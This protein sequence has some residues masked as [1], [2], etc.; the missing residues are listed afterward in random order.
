[1]DFSKCPWDDKVTISG[2]SAI[3]GNLDGQTTTLDEMRNSGID[4][5]KAF[6]NDDDLIEMQ[7]VSTCIGFVRKYTKQFRSEEKP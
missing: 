6:A 3:A 5:L 2:V 1:M 4:V 7:V